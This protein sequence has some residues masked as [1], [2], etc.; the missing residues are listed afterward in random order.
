MSFQ[1]TLLRRTYVSPTATIKIGFRMS[2]IGR[3]QINI[4]VL[5]IIIFYVPELR[6]TRPS[7]VP[8][9]SGVNSFI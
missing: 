2:M 3:I 6:T 8:Y 1:T 7:V 5:R 9:K 4:F